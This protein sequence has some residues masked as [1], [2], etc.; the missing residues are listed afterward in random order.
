MF[1]VLCFSSGNVH[2]CL[3]GCVAVCMESKFGLSA[4]QRTG[5]ER[6]GL[7]KVAVP[8]VAYS[9]P[10]CWEALQSPMPPACQLAPVVHLFQACS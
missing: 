3:G 9:L 8:E 5:L 2:V 6:K 10:Y 7:V 1:G 4:V